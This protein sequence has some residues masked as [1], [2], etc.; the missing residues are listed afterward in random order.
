MGRF[1]NTTYKNTIDSIVTTSKEFINNPYYLWASKSPTIVDY[2][3]I[4][5]KQST[6]DEGSLIEYSTVGDYSP[7][8]YNKI[9]DFV[10]YGIGQMQANLVN[11]EFGLQSDTISGEAYII[12]NTINPCSGDYFS[13]KYVKENYIFKVVESTFDTLD[14]GSNVYKISYEL[15]SNTRD[16]LE[17]NVCKNYKFLAQNIGTDFNSVIEIGSIEQIEKID[18]VVETLKEYYVSLFYNK[19]VETFTYKFLEN[20][21]YDPYMIEFLIRND[22]INFNGD[23]YVYIGHQTKLSPMFPL[24]YKKTL[25][26]AMEKKDKNCIRYY[27]NKAMGYAI[28]AHMTTFYSRPETY[29]EIDYDT[30]TKA[31]GIIPT[32][33]DECIDHIESGETFSFNDGNFYVYNILI[34]YFNDKEIT[35]ED[36]ELIDRFDLK[37]HH[38]LFY[39][40]PAIIFCLNK[41]LDNL[42]QKE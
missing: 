31:W 32:F 36:L 13:I 2:Y 6:L 38:M 22:I 24:E 17:E 42:M 39:V 5:M 18:S 9:R 35:D 23:D 27:R 12:P 21:F 30:A 8:R 15:S 37:Q 4:N 11:E 34:K 1:T 41:K 28:K 10:L 40:I 19:R 29:F 20:N 16:K 14:N 26:Y 3:N 33:F 7:I 25:F